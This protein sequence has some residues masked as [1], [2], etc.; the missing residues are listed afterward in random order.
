MR[1]IQVT[2]KG[3]RSGVL[4]LFLPYRNQKSVTQSGSPGSPQ[5]ENL[6]GRNF[7]IAGTRTR[8]NLRLSVL[9]IE[10]GTESTE[11]A[12]KAAGNGKRAC[13]KCSRHG[14]TVSYNV[15]HIQA[16]RSSACSYE[17][18]RIENILLLKTPPLSKD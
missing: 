5:K 14:T 17:T 9:E 10:C 2:K 3:V 16:L 13:K 18:S 15:L 12:E 11:S 1:K 4:F 8:A 6:A 7:D